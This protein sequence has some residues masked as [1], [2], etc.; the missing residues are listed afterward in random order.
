MACYLVEY[1]T[2]EGAVDAVVVTGGGGCTSAE[3]PKELA[4]ISGAGEA[5]IG[6]KWYG[7]ADAAEQVAQ[8]CYPIS[9]ETWR[10]QQKP[11]QQRVK[12]TNGQGRGRA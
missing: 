10:E 9:L 1:V 7:S 6:H 3:L 11:W 2:P 12:E 4:R 8:Y 5:M